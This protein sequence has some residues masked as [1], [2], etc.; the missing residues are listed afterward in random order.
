MDKLKTVTLAEDEIM[1]SFDV[2]AL[3]PS[4]PVDK[5]LDMLEEWIYG[6]HLHPHL[7]AD[8]IEIARL[9]MAQPFFQFNETFYK[10]NFG[11]SMGNSLS[12]FIANIFMS[13]LEM[14]L[15]TAEEIPAVWFRYVDD[16]F[17]VMKR[18]KIEQTLHT[19]NSQF[20]SIKFTYETEVNGVLPFLDLEI[21]RNNNKLEF[22]IY[23]KPTATQRYITSD[24]YCNLQH[25][26]A[27]FNSMTY[28]L[29]NIPLA[30]NKFQQELKEINK[31]AEVNGFDKTIVN[32]LVK[33]QIKNR[34]LKS[35]TK[36]K[37]IKDP[38]TNKRVRINY[39]KTTHSRMNKIFDKHNLKIVNSNTNKIKNLVHSTKDS[40]PPLEK[41]GIYKITCTKCEKYYFGQTRRKIKTR[42][43]EHINHIAKNEGEKSAAAH[44]ILTATHH[45]KNPDHL[46]VELFKTVTKPYLLDAYESIEIHKHSDDDKLLN[47]EM[48]SIKDSILIGSL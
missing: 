31:I 36:L 47:R 13:R 4:I 18:D 22:G 44:H 16:I 48:G 25:K 11:T 24:S 26:H 42:F 17:C 28:R 30:P 20:E 7:A 37:P 10:Q 32:T 23:R 14:K 43:K 27:A 5:A 38:N 41:S 3:Y 9:A 34:N 29:C 35:I 39:N 2:V 21:I 8:Y 45:D 6:L 1:V 46:Q 15:S 33:K 40:T 12:P 19:L